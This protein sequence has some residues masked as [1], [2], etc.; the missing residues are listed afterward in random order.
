MRLRSFSISAALVAL[1]MPFGAVAVVHPAAVAQRNVAPP[2]GAAALGSK[3]TFQPATAGLVYYNIVDESTVPRLT[4]AAA[5]SGSGRRIIP[6]DHD[7]N[8]LRAARRAALGARNPFAPFARPLIDATAGPAPDPLVQSGF[9]G[10][11]DTPAVCNCQP[12]DMALA[13][14]VGD[15]FQGVNSAFA[16]YRTSGAIKPGWPKN[17]N[18]FFGLPRSHFLSDPRLQYDQTDHRYFASSIDGGNTYFLAVSQTENP[19]GKWNVYGFDVLAGQAAGDDYT[20]LATDAHNAYFSVNL[21]GNTFEDAAI[22]EISKAVLERGLT[23]S[24]VARG[25]AKLAVDGRY[26][27]T[28][29]PTYTFGGAPG[30]FFVATLNSNFPRGSGA[31]VC[32]GIATFLMDTSSGAPRLSGTVVKTV[33][34]TSPPNADQPG[35]SQC[36]ETIDNRITGTPV[37]QHGLISFAFSTGVNN[38]AQIVPGIL[39]AQLAP[40]VARGVVTGGRLYQSGIVSFPGDHAASFGAVMPDQNGNLAMVFDSSSATLNPSVYVAA[41]SVRAPLDQFSSLARVKTGLA[42][43]QDFRWG[44]YSAAARSPYGNVWLAGEF[45]PANQ[46]WATFITSPALP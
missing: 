28:V 38:G 16:D 20:L 12:P 11:F 9:P 7:P 14:G 40:R 30:E 24:V 45:A 26:L 10:L 42:R 21:F 44:D 36:L 22:Y 4:R 35:C 23:H 5:L 33:P 41:R 25:F 3:I 34:Y 13:V 1:V 17:A 19:G 37:Y 27:D 29:Q 8:G 2:N 39:W 31:G 15:V 43:T 32:Q 6:L 18:D 46:D